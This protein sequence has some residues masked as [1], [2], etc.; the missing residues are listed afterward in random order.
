VKAALIAPINGAVAV[1]G[2]GADGFVARALTTEDWPVR[3]AL[4]TT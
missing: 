2:I 1:D 3:V 4:N